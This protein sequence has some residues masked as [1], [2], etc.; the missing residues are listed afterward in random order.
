MST[1]TLD[2]PARPSPA[3][4]LSPEELAWMNGPGREGRFEW[5]DG[6]AVKK[7]LSFDANQVAG[8]IA[9]E[10]GIH[11]RSDPVAVLLIEQEFQCF[12]GKPKQVRKPDLCLI[13]N[14]R[15]P[16]PRPT[17]YLRF[18]PDL[19]IEAVS[20]NDLVY[21]LDEKLEDYRAAGFPLVWVINPD[22]RLIRVHVRD[23]PIVELR[24]GDTLRGEPLLPGFAVQVASIMPAVP[25]VVVP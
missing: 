14:D 3:T 4:D 25:A 5:V 22:S 8:N 6:R 12:P 17:G 9:I 11:L 18:V 19:A 16:V 23:R 7:P 2:V 10:L 15:V 21:S 1:A 13:L 20:P 24:A